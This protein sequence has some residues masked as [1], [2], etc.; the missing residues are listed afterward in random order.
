M[1][2][3]PPFFHTLAQTLV[4]SLPLSPRGAERRQGSAS[5]HRAAGQT[6]ERF[7]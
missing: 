2:T 5:Y 6:T 7:L 4:H 3:K 1:T